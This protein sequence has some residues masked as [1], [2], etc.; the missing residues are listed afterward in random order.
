MDSKQIILLGPPGAGTQ[1]QARILAER[2]QLPCVL[3]GELLRAE[4]AKGSELG[5]QA[6]PLLEEGEQ[7]PDEVMITLIRRRFEQ[8]D[9]VL[10]GFV[11][12]GFPQTV[13]QAEALDALLVRFEQPVVAVGYIKAT[14]GILINRLLA[15]EG[16]DKNVAT[17]RESITRYKA[18]TSPVLSY[19]QMGDRVTMINGSRS[20]AE[21]TRDLVQLG[22]VETGAAGFLADEAA[23]D[24]LLAAEP[25]V[26]VDCIASWCGPCKQVS[27]LIDRL[28]EDYS[29]RATVVKL[30]FDNNR[31]VAQRFGLKGMPSVMFFKGGELIET[32][33]GVKSYEVYST[34][35]T[36]I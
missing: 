19:Y 4:I 18:A 3:A 9:I 33:T 25:V 29:D 35:L 13:V 34:T 2:W 23:L 10:N 14:T 20:E 26:V 1:S 5:E 6:R 7:V 36:G 28:A 17:L 32:L 16:A 31:Q 8:P 30:D 22:E 24:A 15:R 27:P 12:E 21:V 11:L